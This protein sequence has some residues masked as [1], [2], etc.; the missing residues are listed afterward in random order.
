MKPKKIFKFKNEKKIIDF[1]KDN[2]KIK[3]KTINIGLAGGK[4]WTKTYK[5]IVKSNLFPQKNLNIYLTDERC[6]NNKKFSN[7]QNIKKIFYKKNYKI[8]KFYINNDIKK[9]QKIYDSILPNKLDII[10]TALGSDGHVLSW[11]KINDLKK[12]KSKTFFTKKTKPNGF[13]RLSLS[14]NYVN[15]CNRI[16]LKINFNKKNIYKK[17]LIK[18]KKFPINF[19]NYNYLIIDEKI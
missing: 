4:S 8:N 9:S 13:N 14:Q 11:F 1:L 10:F 7:Y 15:T 19:L 18:K 2:I 12:Y 5:K 16:F 6:T 3:K 17:T